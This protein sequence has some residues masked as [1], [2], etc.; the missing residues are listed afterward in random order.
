MYV[1]PLGIND[2]FLID[3]VPVDFMENT[4]NYIIHRTYFV[5]GILAIVCAVIAIAILREER[6]III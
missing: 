1:T 3:V 4:S 6:R 5:C 2:W